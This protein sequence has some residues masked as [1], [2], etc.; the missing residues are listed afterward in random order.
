M[1]NIFRK[2]EINIS[3]YF[4]VL[5]YFLCGYI[6]NIMVIYLIVIIHEIGHICMVWLCGYK[7]KKVTIYPFGGVTK[8]ET[9]LNSPLNKDLIVF[10]GG[11][12]FQILL[13]LVISVF[14]KLNLVSE[15]MFNLV[16]KYNRFIF[17]FNIIPIIPLDGYLILNNCFNKFF[18][19]YKCLWISLAFSVLSLGLFLFFYHNNFVIVSFLLFNVINYL[20]NIELLYNRFILERYLYNFPYSKISYYNNVDLKKLK[21]ERL[22]YFMSKNT[23]LSEKNILA[24]KFDNKRSFW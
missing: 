13:L 8:A 11:F 20:K 10:L 14:F 22:C 2:F 23:Y 6:K 7:L 24:K 9:F 16:N 3:T 4:L 19:Y 1:K 18:S 21:R 17:L 12:L 5:L 15:T